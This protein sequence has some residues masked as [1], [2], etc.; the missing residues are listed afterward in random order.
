VKETSQPT[1]YTPRT[2]LIAPALPPQLDGIGDHSALIAQELHRVGCP[3]TILTVTGKTHQPIP[4]IEVIPV[5]SPQEPASVQKI[6]DH[7]ARLKPDLFLVQYNPFSYGNRGFN[8]YL[9][10]V[11][12]RV[13]KTL[14]E[15]QIAVMA[16]ETFLP[17]GKPQWAVMNLWQYPQF[18]GM[19]RNAHTLFLSIEVWA[20]Q[21]QKWFPKIP[22]CHLPVGAN[23]PVIPTSRNE[24]KK[25]L[26][27][28]P[29]TFVV[30]VFGTAH[31][32]RLFDWVA[33]AYR[34]VYQEQPNSLLLYVGPDNEVVRSAVVEMPLNAEGPFPPE[35]VSLRLSAMDVVLA[36]YVDGVST[37]R[38]A[39]MAGLQHGIPTVTTDAFHTDTILREANGKAFLAATEGNAEMFYSHVLQL[40][41]DPELRNTIGEG[42]QTLYCQQFDWKPVVQSLLQ[43]LQKAQLG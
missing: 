12:R 1:E 18:F 23:I 33:E 43:R 10:Q 2:V 11:L 17:W 7:I 39:F 28:A 30:G 27:I 40:L 3:V 35:E 19:G 16:H 42:G 38:G 26:G 37:R 15:T 14:P 34:R 32:S 8:P 13:R 24:A 6:Y 22:V 25:R 36:P 5:F 9:P 29:D 4:G 20:K 41:R 21:F 31:L